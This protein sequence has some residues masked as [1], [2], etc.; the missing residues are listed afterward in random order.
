MII[1]SKIDKGII[2][3]SNQDAFIAGQLSENIAF[4]VVCDGMGGAKAGNV[5]SNT[6]VKSIREYIM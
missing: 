2:R 6:A 3:N 4:A 5:A 1:H